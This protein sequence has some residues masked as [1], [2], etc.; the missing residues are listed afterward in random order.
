MT[1]IKPNLLLGGYRDAGGASLESWY[2]SLGASYVLCVA[3]EIEPPMHLMHPDVTVLHLP[4]ADDDPSDDVTRILEEAVAFVKLGMDNN[5]TVLVHCRSGV[6]RAV[7]VT[8]AVLV[9]SFGYSLVDAYHYII[10]R[11]KHVNVFPRYLDQMQEWS[12]CK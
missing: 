10:S 7:C 9:K 8:L 12:K 1:E 3:S 5:A 6:S 2:R 11:R 4:I